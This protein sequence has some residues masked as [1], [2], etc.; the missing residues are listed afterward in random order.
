MDPSLVWRD[1]IVLA[2]DLAGRRSSIDRAG[3][4][5][6]AGHWLSGKETTRPDVGPQLVLQGSFRAGR[7][8]IL[9]W[10]DDHL[11]VADIQRFD[12][13][14]RVRFV[15]GTI[16]FGD[17]TRWPV[18]YRSATV[19]GLQ[20]FLKA[21]EGQRLTAGREVLILES[22]LA[23]DPED[24]VHAKAHAERCRLALEANPAPLECLRCGRSVGHATLRY[25][26]IAKTYF[27]T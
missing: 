4:M 3:L 26:M 22:S 24:S 13:E 14:R 27:L 5:A 23:A 17:G 18:E 25:H 16:E 7:E 1:L 19:T 11:M 21:P 10:M 15:D 12:D 8:V 6:H 9:A 2:L 20:R